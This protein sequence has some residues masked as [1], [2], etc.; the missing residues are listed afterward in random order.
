[1]NLRT[2]HDLFVHELRDIYDAEKRITK[3]LPKMA[4]SVSSPKLRSALDQHLKVTEKQIQRLNRVFE[5]VHV[6]AQGRKCAGMV[7][8]LEEGSDLMQEEA[9]EPVLDAAVIGAAQKVEHYEIAVYGTLIAYASKLGMTKAAKLLRQTLAKEK[10]TNEDL[11]K[12]ASSIN[13][14]ANGSHGRT[15]EKAASPPTRKASQK[16]GHRRNGQRRNGQRNPDLIT[17]APGSHPG[18]VAVGTAAGGAMLGAAGGAVAGPVGAAIGAIVGGV[19]GG[20]AGKTA[21]EYVEPTT[22]R[23]TKRAR[24]TKRNAS[25]ARAKSARKARPTAKAR[26]RRTK[27]QLARYETR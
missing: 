10:K 6:S 11:T 13:Q 16:N 18:G 5:L 22:K 9:A 24:K 21:A 20:Y 3:A 26:G 17:G 2:L 19:A 23:T 1:M 8:L 25:P 15:G 12:L 7:G 4:R 14:S 27:A